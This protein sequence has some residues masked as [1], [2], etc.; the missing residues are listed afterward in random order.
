VENITGGTEL[1]QSKFKRLGGIVSFLSSAFALDV[2]W[3]LYLCVLSWRGTEWRTQEYDT[4]SQKLSPFLLS[5]QSAKEL[6]GGGFTSESIKKKGDPP[7]ARASSE[8]RYVRICCTST[9]RR[10]RR[11][12]ASDVIAEYFKLKKSYPRK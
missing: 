2:K 4:T 6:N 9:A 7:R 10:D 1:A 11:I 3:M 5:F 8:Y 12:S